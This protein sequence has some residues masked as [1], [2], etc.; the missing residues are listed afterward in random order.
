MNSGSLPF[1]NLQVPAV[2]ALIAGFSKATKKKFSRRTTEIEQLA[3]DEGITSPEEKARLGARTRNTK[4]GHESLATLQN[5]WRARLDPDEATQFEHLTSMSGG[6]VNG[7]A[8]TAEA[9]QQA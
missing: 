2:C 3:K 4:A 1:G 7:P 8:T 9:V 5:A 6:K